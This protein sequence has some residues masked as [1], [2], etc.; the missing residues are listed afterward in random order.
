MSGH[1]PSPARLPAIVA[2]VSRHL[3]VAD[4]GRSVAFYRD[5][6]GFEVQTLLEGDGVPPWQKPLT[7][8]HESSSVWRTARSTALGNFDRADRPFCFFRRMMSR[9]CVTP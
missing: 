4:L 7:A 9:R 2:P 5:V 3:S 8:R 6:L 1:S